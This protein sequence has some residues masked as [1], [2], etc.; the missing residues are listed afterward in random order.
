M[1]YRI[2]FETSTDRN[3]LQ[4]R[5]ISGIHADKLADKISSLQRRGRII[6]E[7]TRES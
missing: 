4:R 6:F 3:S 7:I 1:T 5:Y 2:V